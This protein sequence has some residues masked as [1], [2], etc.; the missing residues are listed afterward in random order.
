MTRNNESLSCQFSFGRKVWPFYFD[1]GCTEHRH[2]RCIRCPCFVQ[3]SFFISYSFS[4]YFVKKEW[5]WWHY[6]LR[7]I[8]VLAPLVTFDSSFFLP[9]PSF[10][11]LS[12]RLCQTVSYMQGYTLSGQGLR[13]YKASGPWLKQVWSCSRM[14]ELQSVAKAA[15]RVMWIYVLRMCWLNL[16]TIN[17]GGGATEY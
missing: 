11:S 12:A 15:A 7:V 6:D 10:F 5:R 13:A 3:P 17:K 14:G 8:S 4:Q 9:L 1:W 16:Q 2:R